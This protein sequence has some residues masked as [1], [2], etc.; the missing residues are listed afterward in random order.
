MFACC[1][2][3]RDARVAASSGSGSFGDALA[4]ASSGFCTCHD[5]R[6][7]SSRCSPVPSCDVPGAAPCSKFCLRFFGALG[8]APLSVVRPVGCFCLPSS[9]VLTLVVDCVADVCWLCLCRLVP[10]VST[11][12]PLWIPPWL[13][14]RLVLFLRVYQTAIYIFLDC[15]RGWTELKWK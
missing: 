14:C 15:A 11:G 9:C 2:T 12:S 4:A 8:V 13:Q 10:S 7:A 3:C 5:A 1:C 6:K